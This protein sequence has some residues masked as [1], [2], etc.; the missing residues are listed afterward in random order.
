MAEWLN[1]IENAK[2]TTGC[3]HGV[4]GKLN[5]IHTA[6]RDAVGDFNTIASSSDTLVYPNNTSGRNG[7]GGIV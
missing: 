5:P 7:R 3:T 6:A 1:M 2:C 4:E